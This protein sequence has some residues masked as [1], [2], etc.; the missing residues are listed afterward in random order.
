MK[1]NIMKHPIHT[2]AKA[3]HYNLEAEHYDIFNEKTS[4]ITN[5]VIEAI[6]R[7][8][9]IKTVLDMTCGTGSQVFWLTKRGYQVVGSDI[10]EKMLKIAAEKAKKTN[11]PI[12]FIRG[13][14]RT[15]QVG[16][17]DAI[18]TIF[19]A[20]GHLTKS[21]FEQ[22][23]RNIHQNL[24]IGGLYLFDIFNLNYLLKGDHITKLTIDWL[25]TKNNL[26]TRTIQ[27]S[28]INTD[29]ILASFTT[30]YEQRDLQPPKISK[31][32]QTLQV[33]TVTDLQAMLQRN[34]F[35]LL[36]CC[37]IDGSKFNEHKTER[38]LIVA[39]KISK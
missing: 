31:S 28:T 13:D 1:D 20:I 36:K 21:D 19:N 32:Q 27:Y 22:A 2:S 14:V 7:K 18:I 34:G 5:T 3:S 9:S 25:K 15:L 23:I 11:L 37:N 10:N 6:L 38:L 33:Y 16:Q 12:K 30:C 35:K 39:K 29:G 8:Y 26:T 4:K 24:T 17:F